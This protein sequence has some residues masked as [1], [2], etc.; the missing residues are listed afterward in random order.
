MKRKNMSA[1]DRT[2]RTLLAVIMAVL[3]FTGAVKGALAY[4]FV[5]LTVIFFITSL[6]G[7]C[8]L[9]V[10]FGISTLKKPKD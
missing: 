3:V 8:P 10:I 1:V 2:I 6:L 5:I 4:I 9:Y 7:F